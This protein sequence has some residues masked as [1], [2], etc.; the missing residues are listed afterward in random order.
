MWG[1][2]DL[3][4]A[5]IYHLPGN[6]IY[7][8]I[9][10]DCINRLPKY[11]LSSTTHFGQFQK[12]GKNSVGGTVL[13][14]TPKENYFWMGLAEILFIATCPSDLTF[15]ALFRGPITLI[16][17]HPRGSEV[18]PIYEYNFLVVINCIRGRISHQTIQDCLV[19]SCPCWG[20]E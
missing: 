10:L 15:L 8:V 13:P 2:A 20:F 11:E 18:V 5:L 1:C 12:F 17:G 4:C 7:A 14:A 19:L 3:S 16:T 6:V 9:G